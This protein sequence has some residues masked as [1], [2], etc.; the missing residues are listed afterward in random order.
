M[1][2]INYEIKL[3]DEGRP[4]IE[5]PED[6]DHKPEDKFFAMEFARYLLNN[7]Y[8]KRFLSE[9]SEQRK[10]AMGYE[11]FEE[12][13][14]ITESILESLEH[15]SDEMAYIIKEG[16][17][18]TGELLGEVNKHR[19]YRFTVETLEE[20]ESI[21]GDGIISGDMI[22][23]KEDG[24]TVLV[25]ENLTIYEFKAE[26]NVWISKKNNTIVKPKK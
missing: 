19:G 7:V 6:Y 24:V 2:T 9:D 5:F 17:E 10:E 22:Y 20:L 12:A 14:A 3:N 4:Y 8:E 11:H 15:I 18:V 1:Y 25:E 13:K 26:E 23:K 16:M 21:E